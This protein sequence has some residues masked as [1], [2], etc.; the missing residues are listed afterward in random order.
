MR[1]QKK[2]RKK[3][4]WKMIVT[5]LENVERKTHWRGLKKEKKKENDL[6]SLSFF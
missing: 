5:I 1:K 6:I 2:E 4:G 3:E